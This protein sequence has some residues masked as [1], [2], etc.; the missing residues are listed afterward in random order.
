[1]YPTILVHGGAGAWDLR[2]PRADEAVQACREAAEAGFAALTAG[3]DILDAVE[4]AIH[5]LEDCPVLD[6]GRGSYLT[7]AGDIEMDALIMDGRTLDLGAVAAVK[8]VRYPIRWRVARAVMEQTQ[9]AILVGAGASQFADEIGFPRCELDDL[10][11]DGEWQKLE[12]IRERKLYETKQIFHQPGSMDTVGA[13]VVD[14]NGNVAAGTSTGGVRG[15]MVGRVGDSPLV[16]SGGY[17]DN[18][19]AAVSSTGHGE[20]LMKVVISRRVCEFIE[21][22]QTV[23]QACESAIAEMMGRVGGKGGLIAVDSK[24]SI[25]ISFNTDAMPHAVRS[26]RMKLSSGFTERAV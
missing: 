3:R 26:S 18:R 20:S 25:G 16:G 24:G 12:A 1:M 22:G 6:A 21:R 2:A 4:A 11:V 8:R 17:A 23:Q 19:T 5:I 15:Q 7:A 14:A 9:H 10:L 13:V